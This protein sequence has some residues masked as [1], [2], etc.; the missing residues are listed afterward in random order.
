MDTNF[1]AFTKFEH[2]GWERVAGQY[3]K[4]WASLTTQFIGPLLEAAGINR[5]MSV[6][7]VACR[8]GYVSAAAKRLGAVPTGIDFSG[9]MVL[10]AKRRNAGIKFVEGNAQ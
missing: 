8:P 9:E 7:D 2:E 4:I 10:R 6:L 1:D 3:E 5:G